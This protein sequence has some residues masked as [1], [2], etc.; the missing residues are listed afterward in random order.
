MVADDQQNLPTVDAALF[1][2]L[3]VCGEVEWKGHVSVLSRTTGNCSHLSAIILQS[4]PSADPGVDMILLPMLVPR[5]GIICMIHRANA[6]VVEVLL[7]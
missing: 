7:N 4:H 2:H 6:C 1:I 5:S 3:E